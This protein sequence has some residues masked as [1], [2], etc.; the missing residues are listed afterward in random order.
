MRDRTWEEYLLSNRLMMPWMSA[1]DSM[2]YGRYLPLYWSMMKNLPEERAKYMKEGMLTASIT[3]KPFSS[4]PFDQWIEMTM[5]KGSKMK[6]G[7]IGITQNEEAL[8]TNIKI[9]NKI[10]KVKVKLHDLAHLKER[11]YKHV[12]CSPSRMKKDEEV[13]QNATGCLQKWNSV[14]WDTE[15]VQLRSLESGLLA[16]QKLEEDF[17]TAKKAGEEK[18]A[19]FFNE[20]ILTNEKKIYDRIPMSKRSNFSKP[21]KEGNVEKA[22]KTDRMENKAMVKIISLAEK[23]SLNLKELMQYRLTEVCLSIFN[24][25]GDIRKAVKSKLIECFKHEESCIL[26][27]VAIVDMGFIWRKCIPNAGEREQ[28]ANKYTWGD[29]AKKV[30][31]MIITR[32][33]RAMEYHL[34]NDRYDIEM[35][36]KDAEH[37]KR[38]RLFIGGAKNIYPATDETVPPAKQFNG[39]FVNP[40][41]KTRLQAFLLEEFKVLAEKNIKK[42]YYTYKEKCFVCFPFSAKQSYFCH[43]E[44]VDTR[45]FYH[46]KLVDQRPDVDSIIIDAED[47][48]VVVISAFASTILRK[49]LIWYKRKQKYKCKDLCQRKVA[50]VLIGF[51]ALTG[52]D[53]VSGF[54]RKS[55]KTLF[56]KLCVS[57]ESR[58]LIQN[59]GRMEH[60]TDK[61]VSN[62]T[63]FV[64]KY[65]YND[66]S[67]LTLAQ[68][69]AKKW[70][71]MKNKTTL[72]LPPDEDTFRQHLL[73]ANYQAKIWYDFEKPSAPADPQQHGYSY[74]GQH[75]SPV[76]H[77]KIACPDV[78]PSPES[79][80]SDV[81]D[82]DESFSDFEQYES[83][84]DD[85]IFEY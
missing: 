19:L 42:V 15:I 62:V 1:Y 65:I 29:Y 17:S 6:G 7:W 64:I 46:A 36:I 37:K 56:K 50:D 66:K 30:F 43:Q 34:V 71:S 72:G 12:E 33:P 85:M 61:E 80:E 13:V 54:Y 77:T 47:T 76:C 25:N 53:A 82:S 2:H 81:E 57:N 58:C 52:A 8:Q 48:D 35:S 60:L 18:L 3:G 27:E 28:A 11:Q 21:P 4:I 51:H 40:E 63:K 38:S 74:N 78:L 83:S 14:P 45:M 26:P 16:S 44:E 55:K 20:R 22:K 70:K 73:R 49:N 23:N 59:I 39:F 24:I 67:S 84:D 69:R 10:A 79:E 68:A 32:H 9:V 75:L 41:N 5:N 31:E